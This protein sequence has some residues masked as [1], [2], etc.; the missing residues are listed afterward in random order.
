VKLARNLAIVALLAVPVAFVPGGGDAADGIATALILGL[1]AGIGYLLVMFHRQ[2]G[3]TLAVME[4]TRRLMAY[5]AVGVIF[6]M[7]AGQDEMWDTAGGTLVWILLVGMSAAVIAL[8]WSE[9][10]RS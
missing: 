6:L 5:A 10:Q 8:T 2:A 1:L 4:D 9:A 3:M 7:I